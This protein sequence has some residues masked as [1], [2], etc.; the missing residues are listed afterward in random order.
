MRYYVQRNGDG[1]IATIYANPQPQDDGTCL[2]DPD[3][4]DAEHP[5]VLAFLSRP[6]PARP[7]TA[8]QLRLG[9]I[10]GGF[11]LAAVEAAIDEIGD[12]SA[13]EAARIEWEYATTFDREHH[14]IAQ[15]G[16]ALSLTPEQIDLMWRDAQS[17]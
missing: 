7:L 9:L 3:P 11:S 13:R 15:I 4:L 17:L 16:A 10:A 12:P 6:M 2:T 1:G 14:L 8:R 5:E